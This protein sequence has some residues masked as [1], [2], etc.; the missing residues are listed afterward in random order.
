VDVRASRPALLWINLTYEEDDRELPAD[1]LA[2]PLPKLSPV[3]ERHIREWLGL[4][5]VVPFVTARKQELLSLPS[6]RSYCHAPGRLHM[7]RFAQ[8]VNRILAADQGARIG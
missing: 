5:K 3:D 8:A 6:D 1:V 2:R 4:K 7:M